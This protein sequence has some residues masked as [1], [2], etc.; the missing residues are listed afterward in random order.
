MKRLINSFSILYLLILF[1]LIY[2]TIPIWTFQYTDIPDY[3][4][5]YYRLFWWVFW[6]VF[7]VITRVFY[8]IRYKTNKHKKYRIRFWILFSTIF[9]IVTIGTIKSQV[10][11]YQYNLRWDKEW[12]KKKEHY[13]KIKQ[14]KIEQLKNEIKTTGSPISFYNYGYYCRNEGRINEAIHYLLKANK[15]DSTNAE[16][17]AELAHCLSFIEIGKY[18]ESIKHFKLAYKLDSTY[19]WCLKSIDRCELL[20]KQYNRK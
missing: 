9:S 14:L 17:H 16:F 15:L 11:I 4:F 19:A 20:K 5:A 18:D 6:G 10:Y 3:G 13:K 1:F 8:L 2:S 12:L 7:L